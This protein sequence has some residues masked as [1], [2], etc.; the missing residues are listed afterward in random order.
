[1]TISRVVNDLLHSLSSR[2][3]LL[4]R[5]PTRRHIA[6][7]STSVRHNHSNYCYEYETWKS[8]KIRG[9]EKCEQEFINGLSFHIVTGYKV[10]P[11]ERRL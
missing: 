8:A 6:A 9:G 2:H 3:I 7:L 11:L 1:V 5:Y 4:Y 10:D